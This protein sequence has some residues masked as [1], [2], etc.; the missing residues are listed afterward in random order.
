MFPSCNDNTPFRS[1]TRYCLLPVCF[2]L[3]YFAKDGHVDFNQQKNADET[4]SAA[5]QQQSRAFGSS[6]FHNGGSAHPEL[7]RAARSKRDRAGSGRWRCLCDSIDMLPFESMGSQGKYWCKYIFLHV[8]CCAQTFQISLCS[9]LQAWWISRLGPG[10]TMKRWN[11]SKFPTFVKESTVSVEV[12][13]SQ[14]AAWSHMSRQNCLETSF[15]LSCCCR[16]G[17]NRA[18]MFY[19]H[20]VGQWTTL[21]RS[22]SDPYHIHIMALEATGQTAS[23]DA[24]D[25]E[26]RHLLY[27]IDGTVGL[28]GTVHTCLTGSTLGDGTGHW[29]EWSNITYHVSRSLFT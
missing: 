13:E 8:R 12:A 29:G 19:S 18:N 17:W 22:I 7:S 6:L 24:N 2:P 10:F 21:L 11:P 16:L 1:L 23:T 27:Y 15:L 20:L 3:D 14:S 4:E 28:C 5:G 9:P 25:C 26:F